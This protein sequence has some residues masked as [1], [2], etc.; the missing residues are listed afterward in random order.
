VATSARDANEIQAES[1]GK[2]SRALNLLSGP[3]RPF[4]ASSK[5]PAYGTALLLTEEQKILMAGGQPC[6]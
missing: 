6:D 1:S 2:R 4:M 5:E 3:R